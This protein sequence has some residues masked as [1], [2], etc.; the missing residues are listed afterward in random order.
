MISNQTII[1][2]W[3]LAHDGKITTKD[4]NDLLARGYYCNGEHYVS[5][6]LG[7]MVKNGRLIRDKRGHYKLGRGLK[8]ADNI[9]NPK[10]KKLF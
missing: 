8:P 5:M 1:L 7:R 9:Q 4:A 3:A 6:L 10:Q 2:N